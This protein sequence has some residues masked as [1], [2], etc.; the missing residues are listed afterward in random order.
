MPVLWIDG[1]PP[2]SIFLVFRVGRADETLA[3]SGIT[4]LVEHLAFPHGHADE[5]GHNG[6]TELTRTTFY[7]WGDPSDAAQFIHRV[8]IGLSRPA[9][10]NIEA[11]KSI[12]LT[13]EAGSAGGT[14]SELLLERYGPLGPGIVGYRQLGLHGIGAGHV[15][16]WSSRF[17]TADNAIVCMTGPPPQR[18]ALELPRGQRIPA[19]ES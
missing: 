10:A 1:P 11:Q 13:E 15:E 4:H 8:S 5:V 17:F 9:V 12:I 18:L 19:A 16:A 6:T 7:A 2:F 3:V 14:V